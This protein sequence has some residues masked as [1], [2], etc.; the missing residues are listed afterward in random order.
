MIKRPLCV[1]CLL[2]MA[3]IW[4]CD[5]S[6][7]SGCRESS[8]T[9][10]VRSCLESG[11][12]AVITGE[13]YQKEERDSV[14]IYYLKNVVLTY[15]SELY[16]IEQ[17]KVTYKPKAE[18]ALYP[19]GRLLGVRG[20]L[21]ETE[22][23]SN[24]GQFN[25]RAYYRA[26]KVY[27]TM[28]GEE[29]Q[30]AGESYSVYKEALYRLRN[31]LKENLQSITDERTGAILCA[32]LLGEKSS[33]DREIKTQFQMLGI[34]HILAISGLHLSILGMGLYKGLRKAGG[35][36]GLSAGIA[37]F[38]LLSY[39]L[40]TGGSVAT[41]RAFI[42]FAAVTGAK[43][44]GRTYDLLSA[45]SLAGILLLM[46]SPGY[47]YD[48]SFLLSFGAILGIGLVLPLIQ[49][50]NT[51]RVGQYLLS[52]L[53]VWMISTPVVLYFFYE[54]PLY[55]FFFNLLVLPTVAAVL[56][57]GAGGMAAAF[58]SADA[59]KI[60]IL[61]AKYLLTIY[62]RA[63]SHLQGIPGITLILGRPAFWKIVV[64][65]TVLALLLLTWRCGK[66]EARRFLRLRIKG[67]RWMAA[68]IF[69][70]CS[71]PLMQTRNYK[72]LKVTFLDVGQGDS[73]VME[74]PLGQSFL[75]DGGSSSIAKVGTY[76]ILPFLK[77]EGIQCLDYVMVSH[78]DSDHMNGIQELLEAIEGKQTS[79]KIRNLVLSGWKD[80][81]VELR[82][83]EKLGKAA[84]CRILRLAQGDT[85]KD[86]MLHLSCLH[87]DRGFYGEET[88]SGSQV[89]EVSYGECRILF[90]GDLEGEGEQ[91][92]E[93]LIG[94]DKSSPY[95]ILK[96]AHHGSRN[97]SGESFL[98][99]VKPKAAVISSGLGNSYGH[100]H[101]ETLER[102]KRS[103][104]RIFMTWEGGAVQA[105]LDGNKTTI[106]KYRTRQY[107]R[108]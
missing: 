34:S 41:L 32:M 94:E 104:S 6:G 67:K 38:F 47:L 92:V 24:P 95:D 42:M 88:N 56:I 22:L 40:L 37:V 83:L 57:S 2:F 45:L 100:P 64:Y 78:T 97:S 74:T 19:M 33:M 105:F 84:G 35:S 108:P 7:L 85:M 4:L 81:N 15:Q 96:V 80:T 68:A 87:P 1:M 21:K 79:L 98:K 75:I 13:L 66:G 69:L 26:R 59:G 82:K 10:G 102:L 50:E 12:R 39:G 44:I 106:E 14:H 9:P 3:V 30:S 93:E 71:L 77:Y 103:G 62:Q 54:V 29:L 48:S 36:L 53:A 73:A 89:I 16:P 61:P 28:E 72:N 23:P 90:T 25:E 99:A 107:N 86:G 58:I 31:V 46:D 70:L 43:W 8:R 51:G 65:Y 60:L 63:G 55:G 27:Y 52:G 18:E 49:K 17:V 20:F 101:K 5:I 76:R 11:E 91:K